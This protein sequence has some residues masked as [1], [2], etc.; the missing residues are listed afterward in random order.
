MELA[1]LILGMALVTFAARYLMI[2]IM[3]RWNVPPML[4]RALTYVPMAAFAALI[5]PDLLRL[6]QASI[7]IPPN[8]F[9]AGVVAIF[10]AAITRNTLMTIIFGMGSLWI[11]QFLVR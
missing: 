3:G 8:R 1:L 2:F 9:I 5:A 4:T 6:E 7:V 10:V 11:V